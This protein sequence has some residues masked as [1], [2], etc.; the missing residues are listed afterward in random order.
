MIK[1]A[2][3]KGFTI[4]ELLIVIVVIGILAAITIVAYNGIQQRTHQTVVQSDF[5][6]SG[7]KLEEYRILNT[8]NAYPYNATMFVASGVK[9]SVKSYRYIAYCYN[10]ASSTTF[11]L[12]AMTI[13]SS[14]SYMYTPE[15]GLKEYNGNWSTMNG[16]SG[17]CAQANTSLTTGAWA[18]D[19]TAGWASG[20]GS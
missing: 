19:S 3:Q 5:S 6:S 16:S 8:G 11:A 10:S 18:Y 17:I 9:F 12:V 20:W 7:K 2:K 14:K 1:V 15:I 4:V 13:D